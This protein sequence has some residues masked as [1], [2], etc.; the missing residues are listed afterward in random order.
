MEFQDCAVFSASQNSTITIYARSLNNGCQ[1]CHM[2]KHDNRGKS[3][4]IP[5][6][7]FKIGNGTG[8]LMA[9][10]ELQSNEAINY[11]HLNAEWDWSFYI[12]P[13]NIVPHGSQTQSFCRKVGLRAQ[14]KALCPSVALEQLSLFKKNDREFKAMTVQLHSMNEWEAM[15]VQL[16]S[17]DE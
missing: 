15:S 3:W 1:F 16:H 13:V 6:K 17:M 4:L 9:R 7:T 2:V 5:N 11:N 8:L 10:D 12:P 14:Y